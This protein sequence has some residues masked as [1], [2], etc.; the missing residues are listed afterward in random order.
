[1]A[2]VVK[3]IPY[4]CSDCGHRGM[5]RRTDVVVDR[6]RVATL[7]GVADLIWGKRCPSCGRERLTTPRREEPDA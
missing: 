6:L 3:M 2:G 7:Q 1:M 4:R 5:V